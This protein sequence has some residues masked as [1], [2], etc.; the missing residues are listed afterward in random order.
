[1]PRDRCEEVQGQFLGATLASFGT[2]RILSTDPASHAGNLSLKVQYSSDVAVRW[3]HN[4]CAGR[5]HA[6]K[7]VYVPR[8]HWST[9]D[10]HD[11]RSYFQSWYLFDIF[12][13]WSNRMSVGS[14]DSL[15][16]RAP[17]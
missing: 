4:P 15:F 5:H 10:S 2:G 7:L 8:L 1:M 17:L 9:P 11:R 3:V 12:H 16:N 13:L 6:A 14:E